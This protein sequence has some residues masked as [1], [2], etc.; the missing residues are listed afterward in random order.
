M[1]FSYTVNPPVEKGGGRGDLAVLKDIAILKP[2][3]AGEK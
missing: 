3:T 1:L 2:D